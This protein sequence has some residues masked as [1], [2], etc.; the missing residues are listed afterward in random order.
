MIFSLFHYIGKLVVT[1]YNMLNI[2][3]NIPKYRCCSPSTYDHP[4]YGKLI[5]NNVR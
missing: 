3:I 1:I 5:A 4:D 2:Q